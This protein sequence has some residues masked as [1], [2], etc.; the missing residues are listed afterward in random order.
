MQPQHS[1]S[2][3]LNALIQGAMPA[4]STIARDAYNLLKNHIQKKIK[5]DPD[6]QATFNQFQANPDANYRAMGDVL[7]RA[8][9]THDQLALNHAQTVV[10]NINNIASGQG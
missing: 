4:A 7:D 9:I 2:L 10:Y 3:I 1:T 6:A 8:G 5:H